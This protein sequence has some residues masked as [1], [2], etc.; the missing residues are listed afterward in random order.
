[1][2]IRVELA[3]DVDADAW[4]DAHQLDGL[5]V[6][7]ADI[8][9]HVRMSAEVMLREVDTAATVTMG[10]WNPPP[11]NPT[12]VIR[13]ESSGN[14]AGPTIHIGQQ[15]GAINGHQQAGHWKS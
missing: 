4:A 5:R 12:V 7:A 1:M 2:R 8:R 3:I 14:N 13:N 11:K 6:A 15:G 9:E 10:V